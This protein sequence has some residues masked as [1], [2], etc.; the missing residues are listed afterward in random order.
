[1]HY[2]YV[3][4][5]SLFFWKYLILTVNLLDPA[6]GYRRCCRNSSFFSKYFVQCILTNLKVVAMWA[7]TDI[8]I[9]KIQVCLATIFKYFFHAPTDL[10]FKPYVD[11]VHGNSPPHRS[12][13]LDYTRQK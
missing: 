11:L 4:F 2:V 6:S 9:K 13:L 12:L 5:C 3:R 10:P 8:E 1:M 7:W